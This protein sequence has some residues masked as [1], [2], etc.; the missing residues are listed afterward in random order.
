MAHC[1]PRQRVN[2]A[3]RLNQIPS[4]Y[5]SGRSWY[6][7]RASTLQRVNP[8]SNHSETPRSI[9]GP[10]LLVVGC[11]PDIHVHLIIKIYLVLSGTIKLVAAFH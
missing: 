7:T 5:V 8:G 10:L 11:T 2:L 9:H 6:K 1:S 4:Q 3:T